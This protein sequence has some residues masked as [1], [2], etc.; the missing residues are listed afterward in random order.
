MTDDETRAAARAVRRPDDEAHLVADVDRSLAQCAEDAA[1]EPLVAWDARWCGL[2]VPAAPAVGFAVLEVRG[3]VG[4][5]LRLMVAPEQRG[6]GYGRALLDAVVARA[7]RVPSVE[8]VATSHRAEN[9][10]MA[11]LCAAAGFT[12]WETPFAHDADEVYLR[13]P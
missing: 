1:L 10:V 13:L 8:M 2:E 6:Q 9:T 12:A 7:R 5:V 11:S 4:F 3:G